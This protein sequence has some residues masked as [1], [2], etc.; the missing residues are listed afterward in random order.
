MPPKKDPLVNPINNVDNDDTAPRITDES[1]VLNNEKAAKPVASRRKPSQT[2]SAKA[3]K[4]VTEPAVTTAHEES[5][6]S[7]D[8]IEPKPIEATHIETTELPDASN[9][10]EAADSLAS[11][12]TSAE[13]SICSNQPVDKRDRISKKQRKESYSKEK[14][15]I[16]NDLLKR[17]KALSKSNGKSFKT[18]FINDALEKSLNE[19]EAAKEKQKEDN[20]H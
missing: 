20:P 3:S 15:Y 9:P 16:R 12:P 11:N 6:D 8:I 17:I 18:S 19:L 14:L 1:A 2:R 7:I 13:L 10:I 4:A 5:T